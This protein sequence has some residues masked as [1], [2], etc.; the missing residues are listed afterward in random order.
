[1]WLRADSDLEGGKMAFADEL[2]ARK[3]AIEWRV[4]R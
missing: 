3:Q 2:M 1:M 4:A